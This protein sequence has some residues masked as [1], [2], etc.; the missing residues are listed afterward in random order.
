MMIFFLEDDDAESKE[1]V[2][3][4]GHE[5]EGVYG[6]KAPLRAGGRRMLLPM[7]GTPI[8]STASM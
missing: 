8:S 7:M 3:G 6:G 2:G 1:V 5:A 4:T